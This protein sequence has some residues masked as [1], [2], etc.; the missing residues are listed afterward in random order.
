M[1]NVATMGPPPSPKEPRRSGRRTAPSASTSKSPAGSPAS[2]SGPKPKETS[3]RPSLSSSSSSSKSKRNKQE[4]NDEPLEEIHKNGTD[5]SGNS[6]SKRK[7]KEKEKGVSVVEI[8]GS[9]E[10][11]QSD[12]LGGDAAGEPEEE[13]EEAGITRCICGGTGTFFRVCWTSCACS[14]SFQL[15]MKS[16]VENSWPCVSCARPGSTVSAWDTPTSTTFLSTTTVSSVDQIFT[17]SFSSAYVS[18]ALIARF[19]KTACMDHIENMPKEPVS[20][21]PLLTILSLL[22]GMPP[23]RPAP[24]HQHISRSRR[25]DGIP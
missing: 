6:R 23:V 13:D 15:K 11:L 2:D 16:Q 4:E 1:A 17:L 7:P 14:T 18:Y 19:H 5:G 12:A 10:V 20:R 25:N 3:H 9:E 22:P 8:L 24:V 21:Q